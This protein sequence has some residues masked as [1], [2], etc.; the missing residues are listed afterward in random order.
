MAAKL[1]YGNGPENKILHIS[2]VARGRACNC[3]CPE[4]G[5]ELIARKGVKN[6]F[7]FAHYNGIE[8]E[9]AP[10]TAIH[11]LAKEIIGTNTEIYL[12]SETIFHYQKSEIEKGFESKRPDVT[13]WNNEEKIFAEIV[14]TNDVSPEKEEWFKQTGIKTLVIDLS[15]VDRDISRVNLEEIVLADC[16]IRRIIS[17]EEIGIEIKEDELEKVRDE[18]NQDLGWYI[19]FGGLILWLIWGE[20]IKNK[21]YTKKRYSRLKSKRRNPRWK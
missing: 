6:E 4:C 2:E 3:T 12:N 13:I 16:S 21:L 8:C 9:N 15:K 11:K 17:E 14:V 1:K 10:E 5:D 20:D 7:H 19:V 18:N